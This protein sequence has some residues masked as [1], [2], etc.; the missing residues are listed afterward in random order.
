MC[1]YPFNNFGR[2]FITIIFFFFFLIRFFF[3]FIARTTIALRACSNIVVARSGYTIILL[4]FARTSRYPPLCIIYL[5]IPI[6]TTYMIYIFFKTTRRLVLVFSRGI[7]QH[8]LCATLLFII[9]IIMIFFLIT[10]KTQNTRK[11]IRLHSRH[12]I[13]I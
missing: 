5:Y 3:F 9:I 11:K 10:P 8:P 4:A 12:T 7:C 2:F 1:L 13:Y 6:Y